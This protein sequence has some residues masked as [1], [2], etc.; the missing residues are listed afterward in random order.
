MG[1]SVLGA[2]D[3]GAS[4]G[5]AASAFGVS[6]FGAS[7]GGVVGAG[8]V[9]LLGGVA[10]FSSG[11]KSDGAGAGG[12]GGSGAQPT[13]SDALNAKLNKLNFFIVLTLSR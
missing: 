8:A 11:I 4:A 6:V 10:G 2:S 13:N 7:A 3:F 12:G 1:A 9:S 5:G